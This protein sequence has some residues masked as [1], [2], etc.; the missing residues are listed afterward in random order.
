MNS[1]KYIWRIARG[2]SISR[3][4]EYQNESPMPHEFRNSKMFHLEHEIQFAYQG[5]ICDLSQY[6]YYPNSIRVPLVSQR[7]LERVAHLCEK[8]V[9][10]VE[11]LILCADGIIPCFLLNSLKTFR[12]V[13][14]NRSNVMYISGTNQILKFNLMRL[15]SGFPDCHV[16]RLEEAVSYVLVTPEFRRAFGSCASCEFLLPAEV[17]P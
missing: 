17:L 16:V 8:E 11:S 4:V 5:Q 14:W 3:I 2:F 13:D 10:I 9:Q 15:L 12:C 6:D 7:G 1:D